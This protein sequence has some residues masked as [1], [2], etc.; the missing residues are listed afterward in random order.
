MKTLLI[1]NYDSFTY[2]LFHL[3]G[4]VNGEEPLILLNNAISVEELGGLVFDN[5][6]LSPGPG[7]PASPRDF[8]VCGAILQRLGD[9]TGGG[10][11]GDRPL[12]GV[13]LGHQGLALRYGAAVGHA[14]APAHGRIDAVYHDGS[15]LFAG[16][17]SPLQVVRYHSLVVH[18]PLPPHLRRTAQTRDGLLMALEHRHRPAWG[19]QFHPESICTEHGA[20]LLQ[21]FRDLTRRHQHRTQVAVPA[22]GPVESAPPRVS[23]PPPPALRVCV[24]R[25]DRWHD[26]E[27]AFLGLFAAQPIGFWLDSSLVAQGLSRFSFMGAGDGPRCRL[28]TY[29]VGASELTVRRGGTTRRL[30]C[31]SFFDRLRAE[32]Q[33]LSCAVP[34]LPFG[35]GCGLVGYLGYELKA[36]TGSPRPAPDRAAL[37]GAAPDAAML[38]AD[39]LLAFDHHDQSVYLLHL[40][41]A[42]ADDH[43]ATAWFDAIERALAELPE[44][45]ELPLPAVLPQ[46]LP[47]PG[48][49]RHDR[50]AYLAQVRACLREIRDGESYEICLT[51]QVERPWPETSGGATDPLHVY[52]VLRRINPAPYAAYLKLPEVTV[53]CSSPERFLTVDRG[54]VVESKPIKGTR[55]R[56][57]TDPVEDTRLR[58]ELQTSPKDRAENL[59]IVDLLRNDLGRICRLGSVHVPELM[60]VESYATVH[61]LVST[62]RGRLRP[63]MTAVDCVRAAFPGGSMT[64]APKLRTMEILERLE[65]GP[66]GIYAGAIGY[67]SLCGA[68][69]LN[70]VIRTL[71]RADDRLQLGIGGAVVALSD[72]EAEFAEAL[73]KGQAPLIALEL[74]ARGLGQ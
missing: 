63:G 67:L 65:R 18:E 56:A 40:V 25:L 43:E 71:V 37:P 11:W 42:Q 16:I 21:N 20:R 70:I 14:P 10:A 72:P 73:L 32:L 39:R 36:E 64:G 26:P 57:P 48:E 13:C 66:R 1:D 24:R 33:E 7:H 31:P 9:G 35:L 50:D 23:E 58:A 22:A 69:D 44:V 38:L 53:L 2:N 62:V 19:V 45:P 8:G 28:L 17:P 55:P 15:L 4:E 12:L 51:D 49:L 68:A 59:M 46:G 34:E 54:G 61:Q 29:D 5:I 74:A 3:I 30:P 41:P 47:R 6:V 27:R 60:A 52:R